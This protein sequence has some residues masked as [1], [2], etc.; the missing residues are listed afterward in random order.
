M[1][2]REFSL[3]AVPAP[4]LVEISLLIFTE[5]NTKVPALRTDSL[6]QWKTTNKQSKSLNE[7]VRK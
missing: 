5:P 7:Y 4:I 3:Q 2:G 1:N 6:V